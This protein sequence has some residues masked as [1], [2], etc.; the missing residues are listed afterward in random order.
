MGMGEGEGGGGGRG[1]PKTG[2]GDEITTSVGTWLK[3]EL[4]IKQCKYSLRNLNKIVIGLSKRLRDYKQ[5]Y[6]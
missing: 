6:L 5:I 3:L 4:A 1:N 2:S